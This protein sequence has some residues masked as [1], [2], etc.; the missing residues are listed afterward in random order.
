MLRHGHEEATCK[1]AQY[2]CFT[3]RSEGFALEIAKVREVL[4]VTTLTKIPRMPDY[5]S[6]VINLRGSV[7]RV[8][9]LG[10]KLGMDAIVR[11][12][13][14]CIMIVEMESGG[15][16]V[17]IGL[18]TDEVLMVLDFAEEEIEAVPR[19]GT[20]LDTQF[21][22]GMGRIEGEKFLIL[23]DIDRVLAESGEIVLVALPENAPSEG[24]APAA[25]EE[26]YL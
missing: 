18:L 16:L 15:S 12:K 17:E 10:Q 2:L 9:D 11:G 4:D 1:T 25:G 20:R 19:M 26:A 23:L 8:M 5:L 21:I 6:G 24:T 3:L 7:V 13:N 22:Q 14:T